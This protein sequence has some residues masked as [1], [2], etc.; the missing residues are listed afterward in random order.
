MVSD[1]PN[2]VGGVGLVDWPTADL[3]TGDIVGNGSTLVVVNLIRTC[4]WVANV[5]SG[6]SNVEGPWSR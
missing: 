5:A 3:V 1:F 6:S 2:F 4:G